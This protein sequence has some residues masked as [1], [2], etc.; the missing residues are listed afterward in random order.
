MMVMMIRL[1]MLLMLLMMM[2][3]TTKM[4]QIITVTDAE[5]K[6][7]VSK[8]CYIV[9]IREKNCHQLNIIIVC[10]LP[11]SQLYHNCICL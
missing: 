3:T 6:A 4:I 8:K 10:L 2:V 11:K 7:T 5:I 9:N 1:R